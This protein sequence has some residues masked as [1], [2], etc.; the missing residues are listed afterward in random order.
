MEIETIT[1]SLMEWGAVIVFRGNTG[2]GRG[3]QKDA[4]YWRGRLDRNNVQHKKRKKVVVS[5]KN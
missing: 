1:G 5:C 4:G 2:G 3:G